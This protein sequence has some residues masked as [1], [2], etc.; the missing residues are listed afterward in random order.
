MKDLEQLFVFDTDRIRTVMQYP[1]NLKKLGLPLHLKTMTEY[2]INEYPNDL[3]LDE[4][5]IRELLINVATIYKV[6]ILED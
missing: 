3:I 6:N 4:L 1:V 5:V 2:Y